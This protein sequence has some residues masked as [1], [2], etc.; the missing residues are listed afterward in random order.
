MAYLMQ[1]AG[2]CGGSRQGKLLEDGP[3]GFAFE[4]QHVRGWVRERR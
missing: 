3:G 2:Q 1:R 4:L